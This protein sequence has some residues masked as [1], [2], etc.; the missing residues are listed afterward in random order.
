MLLHCAINNIHIAQS[1]D[2]VVFSDNCR[3]FFPAEAMRYNPYCDDFGPLN[4]AS[5]VDFVRALED[6]MADHPDSK[7]IFCVG[8]GRRTLTNAVFLLGCYMILKL[9]MTPEQAAQRFLWLEPSHIEPYRDATFAPPDFRLSLLDCW[10][11]LAKGKQHGWV[12]YSATGYMWG[13]VDID[14]YRHYDS[15]A[16]GNL[17]EV[18]PG[19]LVAFQG[20][21]DLPGGAEYRDDASGARVF[22][23]GFYADLLLDMGV[24]T[25]VRLNEA[26][27]DAAELTSRGLRHVEL[28][29]DD[30]TCPPAAVVAAFLAAV[31]AAE[32]AVAVHCKAGLG[33]TGTL[34]AL[35]LMRE[36]GLGAREA[37]GWLRIM[38]PGSVIGEQQRYLCAAEAAMARRGGGDDGRDAADAA[39]GAAVSAVAAGLPAPG[40]LAAQVA[41]GMARRCV[42]AGLSSD[43]GEAARGA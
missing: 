33:R 1:M 35:Y 17:T 30:C 9:D 38:R 31:D 10:R 15:V 32:G 26:R 18:V 20:P 41:E 13:A 39:R 22:S 4:L 34:I 21:V 12:R 16:Q 8:D 5:I 40:E 28:E 43:A 25:V 11:G 2:T 3:R 23:P 7:I 42:R 6:E 29:F 19:K 36:H 24:D 14:E 27:Y 37:M